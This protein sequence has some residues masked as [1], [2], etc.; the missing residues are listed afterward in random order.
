VR[1][2]KLQHHD[3]DDDGDDA[4]AEGL[5]SA[6]V[7]FKTPFSLEGNS[8]EFWL[9][10]TEDI[11][12]GVHETALTNP[13]RSATQ[14]NASIDD[15]STA[16]QA[17]VRGRGRRRSPNADL[18]EDL[19]NCLAETRIANAAGCPNQPI[20]AAP[21][22]RAWNLFAHNAESRAS[23]SKKELTP[24]ADTEIPK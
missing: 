7:H 3:R 6:L 18:K 15:L 9:R 24:D 8:Y 4:V 1:H 2:L 19:A 23:R 13:V 20:R 21:T 10:A 22:Q 12:C 16:K 17:S 11:R 14:R 5:Q